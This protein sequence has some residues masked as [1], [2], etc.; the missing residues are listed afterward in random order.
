MNPAPADLVG[1]ELPLARLGEALARVRT[2]GRTAVF[3]TGP[4]GIGK[5]SLVRT[6]AAAGGGGLQIGWGTAAEASGTP[7]YWPWTQAMTALVRALGPDR[8]AALAG[9]DRDQL[10]GLVPSLGTGRTDWSAEPNPFLVMEAAA[11]WLD[12]V[13]SV[14]PVLVVLDDLQ[15]ADDS[16]LALLEVA[17]GRSGDARVALVGIY[18]DDEVPARSAARLSALV[19]RAVHLPISGL[20]PDAVHRLVERT[21]AGPVSPD[22][23]AEIHRRTAGH[24]FLVRELALLP[25]AIGPGS[26]APLVVREVVE[27]RLQRLPAPTREVLGLAALGG[28]E[29]RPD[30]V[31]AAAGMTA[32]K[33]ETA[34]RPA[35][36]AGVL[37]GAD[38][39]R[40]RFTH[41][42]YRETLAAGIE[43][44]R[45]REGHR[46]LGAALADRAH[47]D[48]S[49]AAAEV[50][51]QLVA[52]MDPE[53]PAPA[54][55][56]ALAAAA[57]D[58]AVHAYAEAAGHLRRLR[59]AA[60]KIGARLTDGQTVDV[61]LAEAEA[62][63]RSGSPLDA[64]GLLRAAREVAG[65]A[66]D[67]R[68]SALVALATAELGSRFA[69]RRD[70]VIAEL[71]AALA[72]GAGGDQALLVHLTAT[73]AREL[74]HSVPEDRDRAEPLSR[75]ALERGRTAGDDTALLAS[76]LARHD[77]L[78]TPGTADER[79]QL[80]REIITVARRAGD[81]ARHAQGLLLLANAE[82]ERGSAA[83]R[84]VLE[85]CLRLCAELG[86]PRHRY[87]AETRRAAVALLEGDLDLAAE[88]MDAAADLGR[89]IREPD[90]ENVW[91]SQRLE[92]VRARAD[93]DELQRF[94]AAAVDH[95]TG[96]PVHAHA[97]AAGF[98]ARSG[99]EQLARRH[100]AIVLDL[101][102]WRADRSYLRSVFLRELASAVVVLGEPKLAGELFEEIR[103]LAAGCAVNGA[104]VVFA[105]SYADTASRLATALGRREEAAELRQQAL[106]TYDRLGAWGWRRE[107]VERV[108]S[109]GPA[110]AVAAGPTAQLRRAGS[111]WQITFAG[112]DVTVPHAKG[113]ADLAVLL[114]RPGREVHVL[115][116]MGSGARSAAAGTAVDRAA[117]AAYRQRLVELDAEA[118][119][120]ERD[121][122]P[123]RAERT[124][125][126]KEALL[127]EVRRATTAE[128][129]PRTFGNH[130]A[131]RARKAVAAR[132]RAA[133]STIDDVL[134]ELADHLNQSIVTGAYCRYRDDA[135]VTWKVDDRSDNAP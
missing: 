90:T 50:A 69:A 26:A 120:A 48:S 63:A 19:T 20:D 1:R 129:Q 97:V 92:L 94:A 30:I 102:S 23:T 80:A 110:P 109:S 5:T 46:A 36:D 32:D 22:V 34:A 15:W 51:R 28:L 123:G 14:R 52:G 53:D 87:T 131:E 126:E 88:R 45:R 49:V 96:A 38:D 79:G 75:Q 25:A 37:M 61:L 24:P 60:G 54:V 17:L 78:W 132:L 71:E 40:L 130:P 55:Q 101:G 81:G 70:D 99:N 121:H 103:P 98:Y 39:E 122:D 116:L 82:L 93:P 7:G 95:W 62:L 12:A 89:R 65:R 124:A 8:A 27:R 68:R 106:D 35:I 6:A 59:S 56:W 127:A 73:L 44:T 31:A 76:L 47:R 43:P 128:G 57:A 2:G 29:V 119:A 115:D 21:T 134:P 42:L 11:R 85:D 117:L 13:A 33:F 91:L 67:A 72:A 86:Q 133:I 112:R 113:L 100:L 135:A 58:S 41:D 114:R 74:Q 108:P 4:A 64:K 84:P 125:M 77:V 9:D 104:L 105:G 66:D 10:A 16:T 18:R 3:V 118:E 83:Y 111:V 107:L